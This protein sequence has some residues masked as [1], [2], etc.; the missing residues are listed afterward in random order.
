MIGEVNC[1][2][3]KEQVLTDLRSVLPSMIKNVLCKGFESYLENSH[4]Q[5]NFTSLTPAT[6][7]LK[8]KSM[9]LSLKMMKIISLRKRLGLLLQGKSSG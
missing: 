8:K 4:E 1:V 7:L 6:V 3:V 5:R 2:K 9:S